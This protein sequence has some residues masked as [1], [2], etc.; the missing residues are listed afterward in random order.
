MSDQEQSSNV[1]PSESTALPL[2]RQLTDFLDS[3]GLEYEV[4]D[5]S[6]AVRVG[7]ALDNSNYSSVFMIGESN[8]LALTTHSFRAPKSKRSRILDILNRLNFDLAF[9]NFELDSNSGEVRF[10]VGYPHYK[11]AF[12]A[13][14]LSPLVFMGFGM[15][16]RFW[17]VIQ[18]V[19]WTNI[20]AEQALQDALEQHRQEEL[21]GAEADE[22]DGEE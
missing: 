9:G 12:P 18:A 16:N 11:Q 2:F 21:P 22:K 10:R 14:F 3:T 13:E 4:I 8:I 19:C 7:M 6:R 1:T 17:P 5:P 15:M 20:S